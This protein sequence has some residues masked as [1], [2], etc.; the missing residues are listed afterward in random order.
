MGSMY[1]ISSELLPEDTLTCTSSVQKILYYSYD[2]FS[3]TYGHKV[4]LPLFRRVIPE[5]F[6]DLMVCVSI[7]GCK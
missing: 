5:R 2:N 3:D 7:Y 6:V 4:L 1:L